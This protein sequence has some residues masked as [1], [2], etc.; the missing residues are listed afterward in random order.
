MG[1][2]PLKFRY[3]TELIQF[4]GNDAILKIQNGPN[5]SYARVSKQILPEQSLPGDEFVL[6][7]ENKADSGNSELQTMR[8]LLEELIR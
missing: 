5:A 4:E 7:I 1:L 8:R 3:P 2:N 6:K